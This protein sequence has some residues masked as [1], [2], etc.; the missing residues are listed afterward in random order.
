MSKYMPT[1]TKTFRG[2]KYTLLTVVDTKTEAKRKVQR[3]RAIGE[4]AGAVSI[5]KAPKGEAGYTRT[6]WAI[7]TRP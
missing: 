5:P 1:A 2:K 3:L 7:Y 6:R 4:A